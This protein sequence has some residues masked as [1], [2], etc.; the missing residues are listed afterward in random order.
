MN[1]W[2]DIY[3]FGSNRCAEF[4]RLIFPESVVR[5][6]IAIQ[7]EVS[8]MIIGSLLW[9]DK[10]EIRIFFQIRRN[11]LNDEVAENSLRHFARVDVPFEY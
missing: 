7:R 2:L 3:G 9:T 6:V 4:P 11:H 5:N 10:P 1:P 8:C